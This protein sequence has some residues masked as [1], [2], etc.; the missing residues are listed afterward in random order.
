MYDLIYVYHLNQICKFCN[1]N[2]LFEDLKEPEN[3]MLCFDF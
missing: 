3:R 1:I 2:F